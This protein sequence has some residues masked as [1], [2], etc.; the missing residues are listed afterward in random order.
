MDLLQLVIRP[1]FI[2]YIGTL[3]AILFLPIMYKRDWVLSTITIPF[4]LLSV[5]T[6]VLASNYVD[7]GRAVLIA[8]SAIFAIFPLV[9]YS[10]SFISFTSKIYREIDPELVFKSAISKLFKYD[11]ESKCV[12][13]NELKVR[14]SSKTSDIVVSFDD[15]GFSVVGK[16][17]QILSNLVAFF[18]ILAVGYSAYLYY[19]KFDELDIAVFA[20]SLTVIAFLAIV[21]L[22]IIFNGLG[23]V[24]SKV[25]EVS[26]ITFSVVKEV[27][28][29][30]EFAKAI[31]FARKIKGEKEEYVE[32]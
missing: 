9:K 31:E 5:V 8:T 19:S 16:G 18:S 23:F 25:R 20:T 13:E 1:A 17:S 3:I 15:E 11:W 6:A 14:V 28:K 21:V 4:F 24:E 22:A 32:S 12:N 2:I 30:L 29:S 7:E 26:T 10:D 27:E